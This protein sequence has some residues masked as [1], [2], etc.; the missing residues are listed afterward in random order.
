[1]LSPPSWTRFN[2]LRFGVTPPPL[3]FGLSLQGGVGKEDIGAIRIFDRETQFEIA[4]AVAAQFSANVR[5]PGGEPMRV[6][7]L[8]EGP[9]ERRGAPEAGKRRKPA[10]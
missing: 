10:G 7:R 3:A 2:R 5:R 6:E 4:E 9:P 8:K 1:M